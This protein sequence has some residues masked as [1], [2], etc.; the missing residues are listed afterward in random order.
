MKYQ[1]DVLQPEDIALCESVQRGLRSKGY[2]QGRFIIDRDLTEL[3]EHAVHHFQ[4]LVMRAVG[5]EIEDG[6]RS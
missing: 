4:T 6:S 1:K 2:N 5:G 3:S